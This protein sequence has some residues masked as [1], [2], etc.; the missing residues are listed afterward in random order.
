MIG[1]RMMELLG[2]VLIGDGIIGLLQ[3]ARHTRLWRKGPKPYQQTMKVLEQ[4]PALARLVGVG[5][6]GIGYWLVSRQEA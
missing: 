4:Q 1:K 2:L 5:L 3:P 6:I